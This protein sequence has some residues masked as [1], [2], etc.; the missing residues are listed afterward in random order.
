MANKDEEIKK[1]VI[2]RLQTMP[3]TIKVAMGAHGSFDREQLISHIKQDDEIGK[4]IIEKELLY[5]KTIIK[6]NETL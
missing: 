6:Q 5:I 4:I 2:A 1:L 3:L